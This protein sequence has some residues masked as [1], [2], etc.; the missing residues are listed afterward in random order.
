MPLPMEPFLA[1][2]S[3]DLVTYIVCGPTKNSGT[4]LMEIFEEG[5]VKREE[6]FIVSKIFQTHHA[7]M[8]E[9]SSS[10]SVNII[11]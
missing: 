7:C 2:F 1:I 9:H 3:V 8:C 5:V 11:Q 10:S 6:M 4:A